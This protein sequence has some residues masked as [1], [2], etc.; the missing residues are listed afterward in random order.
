MQRDAADIH[1]EERAAVAVR[2]GEWPGRGFLGEPVE[3]MANPATQ[4]SM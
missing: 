1:P 3:R 4:Y 2:G